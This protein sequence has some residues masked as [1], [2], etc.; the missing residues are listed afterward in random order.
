MIIQRLVLA[1]A[2][3]LSSA[4]AL[5]Q[6]DMGNMQGMPMKGMDM[7]NMTGM[8]NMAATVDTVDTKTGLV[9]VTT[10]GMKLKLHFPPTALVNLKA[11]D[12]VTI[13]LGFTK[14]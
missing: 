9:D 2:L 1:S 11:G 12:N 8:H 10:E 4:P 5:A 14:P 3:I 7:K 13:H 6:H